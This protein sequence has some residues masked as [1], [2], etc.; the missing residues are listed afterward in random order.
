MLELKEQVMDLGIITNKISKKFSVD[1]T[2]N[3]YYDA[4]ITDIIPSCGSCTVAHVSSSVV[5]P[6]GTIQLICTFNPESTGEVFKR[7]RLK[8]NHG[9]L[10]NSLEFS[11]KAKVI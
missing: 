4:E 9:G 11:F 5:A 2:N 10:I 8:Y 3:G 7:V 6:Q 1:I